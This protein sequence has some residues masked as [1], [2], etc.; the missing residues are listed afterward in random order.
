MKR[1][2]LAFIAIS[3]LSLI[4][5]AFAANPLATDDTGT[6]GMMKFQLESNAEFGWNRDTVNRTTIKTDS[7]AL[8][9]VVTA[10]VL[11]PLDLILIFPFSWQQVTDNGIRT[12]DDGGLNDISLALK[13]R[14][15][16]FGPASLAV[17]PTVTFP[18]GDYNHGLGNARPAYGAAL[19]S[20]AEFK[21]VS[22]SANV[23]Y[24]NQKYTDAAKVTGR[25]DLWNL[26]LAG[27]VEVMTG[28]QL[29]AEIGAA[30]NTNKA[31]TDWPT[32]ITC[33]V[34]YSVIENLDVSLGV[35]V[36]LSTPETDRTLLPGI[37]FKFP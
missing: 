33:G 37:S 16:D 26:S 27:T 14:F 17:K 21:P 10:G 25:T 18:S 2:I 23:G 20:T 19:I 3:S 13:W 4:S 32:F 31:S 15:L 22:I 7:Q 5:S 29:V 11:D 36:G 9:A 6:Q 28:L 30:S 34:I 24:T 8:N 12:Y 1:I 35:K